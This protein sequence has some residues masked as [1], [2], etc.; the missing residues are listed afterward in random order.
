LAIVVLRKDETGQPATR[1]DH[2]AD[3]ARLA[4]D[5]RSG[6]GLVLEGDFPEPVDMSLVRVLE[7]Q[8]VAARLDAERGLTRR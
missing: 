2:W 4:V 7:C 8:E 3:L 5:S 6:A 1:I